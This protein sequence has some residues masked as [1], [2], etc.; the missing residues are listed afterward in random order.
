MVRMWLLWRSVS[1][2]ERTLDFFFSYLVQF[3]L[4]EEGGL[5]G[6]VD[7]LH[8]LELGFQALEDWQHFENVLE[9]QCCRV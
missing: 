6:G 9:S 4:R 7:L 3:V 5:L 1:F 2:Y 8:T